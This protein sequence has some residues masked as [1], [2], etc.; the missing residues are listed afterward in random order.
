M[1]AA[2]CREFGK[3]LVIEEVEL[4]PPRTGEVQVKLVACAI[5]HSDILYAEGAWG[6]ELPAVYGHEASGVVESVGEGV[7][8]VKAGDHVLVT[9]IRSCGTCFYC[10]QGDQVR[11]ETTFPLDE[12]TP[13]RTLDGKPITQGLRTGAFA[14]SVVVDASQLAPIPKDVPLDSASILSCGVITG[15]GAVVNT[16]QITSGS[17][18]VVIGTGGVGLNSVQGAAVAGAEKIIALDLTE[19]KLEA[20]RQF[21]ATHTVNVGQENARKTVKSLTGGRG[22][23]YVFVTVGA[24]TALEQGFKLLCKGGTLVIVGMT[25]DGVKI[26]FD[27]CAFA[28]VE[29][30]ILGS[31]MGSTRLTTD[32]PW[33]VSLYQQERLKLDELISGRYPLEKINEAIADVSQGDALR[34]VIIF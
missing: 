14:E 21:G 34:N 18:V 15:F 27:S 29:Q 3:P 4:L 13:L 17:S 30:R 25:A 2:I 19:A 5:C 9:L 16:A 11:C 1:K 6:G 7:T 32:I 26:E 33:Y 31:K 8:T 24:K 12:Q 28:S 22:A 10:S 23:D 20:S